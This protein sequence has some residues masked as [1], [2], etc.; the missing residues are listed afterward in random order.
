LDR[1]APSPAACR[2]HQQFVV[3]QPE[4]SAPVAAAFLDGQAAGAD[5]R[6]GWRAVEPIRENERIS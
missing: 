1:I 2:L 4:L 5:I 3:P 6:F